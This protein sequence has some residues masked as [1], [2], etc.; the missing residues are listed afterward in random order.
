MPP[1]P[2][3][4][5]TSAMAAGPPPHPAPDGGWVLCHGGCGLPSPAV[6]RGTGGACLAALLAAASAMAV[7]QERAAALTPVMGTAIWSGAAGVATMPSVL[8]DQVAKLLLSRFPSYVL[9]GLEDWRRML[10]SP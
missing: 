10:R 6:G 3:M 2:T 9:L 8:I 7:V 4:P 5:F 1:S